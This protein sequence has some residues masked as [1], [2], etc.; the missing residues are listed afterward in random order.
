MPLGAAAAPR[1]R[2]AR[3]TRQSAGA[4]TRGGRAGRPWP[5]RPPA[6]GERLRRRSAPRRAPS[7]EC[8][9]ASPP[10]NV[11]PA[12]AH[13]HPASSPPAATAPGPLLPAAAGALPQPAAAGPPPRPH[14]R[15][16]PAPPQKPRSPPQSQISLP[17][18]NPW[19][20]PPPGQ[21][22]LPPPGQRL[23]PRP[24]H[25]LAP[26]RAVGEPQEAATLTLSGWRA[27]SSM[28]SASCPAAYPCQPV[29]TCAEYRATFCRWCRP[30][31]GASGPERWRPSPRALRSSASCP[32]THHSPAPQTGW[33]PCRPPRPGQT[34]SSAC[35][36]VQA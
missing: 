8:S 24:E 6:P 1:H 26:H 19:L 21:R 31:A 16:R 23:P 30:G 20:S 25:R 15:C 9:S 2:R 32:A 7:R 3:S 4:C 18:S 29:T 17:R 10:A 12:V 13:S 34:A 35:H 28:P 5:P 27:G 14:A 11:L 33:D 22:L 36:L